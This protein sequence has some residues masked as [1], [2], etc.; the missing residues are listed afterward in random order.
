M[1][2]PAA[3]AALPT[4]SLAQLLAPRHVPGEAQL[5]RPIGTS[6]GN[7]LQV[8]DSAS[9]IQDISSKSVPSH[10]PTT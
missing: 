9:S 1:A 10:T 8:H 6:A 3:G 2:R 7:P 5:Q 4:R